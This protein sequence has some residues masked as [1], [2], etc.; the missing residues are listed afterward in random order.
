M[1]GG[2]QVRLSAST[3]TVQAPDHQAQAAAKAQ[4]AA[5]LAEHPVVRQAAE[6]FEPRVVALNPADPTTKTTLYPRS[7]IDDPRGGMGN[8][9]KQ[10]QK[11]QEQMLKVQ[12]ELEAR[13]VNARPAAAWWRPWSTVKASCCA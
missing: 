8:L 4:A 1:D 3:E 7:K 2:S 11:M 6:V 9:M 13:E 10:A 5:E 12:Q